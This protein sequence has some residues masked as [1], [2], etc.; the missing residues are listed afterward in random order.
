MKKLFRLKKL[1]TFMVCLAA[2]TS[3]MSFSLNFYE[4]PE[5]DAQTVAELQE[6]KKKNQQAIS[7]LESA[8]DS[9]GLNCTSTRKGQII[10]RY[11]RD[12]FFVTLK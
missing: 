12:C 3:I 2:M 11:F 5:I 1:L 6:Q 4:S 7:D 8:L 10:K 9:L